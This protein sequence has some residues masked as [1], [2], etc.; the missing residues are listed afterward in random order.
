MRSLSVCLILDTATDRP[1]TDDVIG[2]PG[3]EG[4]SIGAPSEGDAG[5]LGGLLGHGNF[6][7]VTKFADDG[8]GFEIPDLDARV[9]GGA[10]PVSVGGEAEGVNDIIGF[11]RVQMLAFLEI[12]QHRHAV[13][14]TGSA[15]RAVG[16]DGHGVQVTGVVNEGSSELAI[17]QVPHFD[18]LVPTAGNN[19]R[20]LGARGESDTGYPLGVALVHDGV[21][22]LTEGVPQLDS[23]IAGSR[24]DLTIVGGER[25]GKD[26]LGVSYEATGG[27][28]SGEIPKT[29]SMVPRRR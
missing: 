4:A 5:W 21:L 1:D 28:A 25:H 18:H 15:Q 2:V 11:K 7:V 19:Q 24:Y 12:P 13:L 20:I 27:L 29:E 9:R 26:I 23:S 8:L 14:T 10:K 6:R 3:E 22:A 16:R 17:C